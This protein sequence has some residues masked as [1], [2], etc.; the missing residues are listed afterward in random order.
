MAG[1]FHRLASHAALNR[2]AIVD[3]APS[4]DSAAR[5][6][7][8]AELLQRV[9]VYRKHLVAAAQRANIRLE[10]ARIG[11]IVHPGV[12]FIA[13]LLGIWSVTAIVGKMDSQSRNRASMAI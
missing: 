3:P 10:G 8:Y 9:T 5:Q 12:D 11:L 7:T 4:A 2:L 13:A 1:Y 6:Y